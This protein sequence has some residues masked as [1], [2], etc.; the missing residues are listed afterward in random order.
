VEE[1]TMKRPTTEEERQEGV[2]AAREYAMGER[3]C[4]ERAE[5]RLI[6]HW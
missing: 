1:G 2:L 5:G 3:S 4:D 6:C